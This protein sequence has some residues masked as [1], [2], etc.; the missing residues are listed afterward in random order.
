V[1]VVYAQGVTSFRTFLLIILGVLI[2]LAFERVLRRPEPEP[3]AAA[4][5]AAGWEP[6]T[7]NAPAEPADGE[8]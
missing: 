7:P 8:A 4:P 2:A 5:P 6:Q 3:P 1:A